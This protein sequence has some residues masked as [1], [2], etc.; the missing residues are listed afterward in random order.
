MNGC[1]T[2]WSGD[3]RYGVRS[4]AMAPGFVALAVLCLGPGIGAA[5]LMFTAVDS[6]LLEPPPFAEPDRLVAVTQV[7]ET[8]P[9]SRQPVSLGNYRELREGAADAAEAAAMRAATFRLGSGEAARRRAGALATANLFPVLGIEPALGRG[10]RAEDETAAP[11]PVVLLS[12]ETWRRDFAGDG[13][14][15]G[16]TVTVDGQARTI[17]GVLPRLADARMPREIREARIWVPLERSVS[18]TDTAVTVIARLAAG[19]TLEHAAARFGSIGTELATRYPESMGS[20][21]RVDELGGSVSRST[22]DMLLLGMGSAVLVLLI[23]CANVANLLL[24]R[25]TRRRP[26]LAIRAALGASPGRIVRQLLFESLA[27]GVLGAVLGLVVARWSRDALLRALA[28]LQGAEITMPIDASVLAFTIGATVLS[29]LLFGLVPALQVG[30]GSAPPMLRVSSFSASTGRGFTRFRHTLVVGQVGWA[31][32]LLAGA[33][34]LLRSFVSLMAV[35]G[36]IDTENLL[37]VELSRSDGEEARAAPAMP[38]VEGMLAALAAL[39]GVESAAAADFLP[40]RTSGRRSRVTLRDTSIETDRLPTISYASVTERFFETLRTRLLQGSGFTADVTER[41]AP[42]A[43]VNERMAGQLWRRADPLGKRFDLE[44][45][46]GLPSITVI[47]VS[48]DIANWDQS[49]VPLATAYVRFDDL[50]V[51]PSQLLLRMN[52]AVPASFE[53]LAGAIRSIAPDVEV[54]EVAAMEDVRRGAFWRQELFS[55]TLAVFGAAA[56]LLSVL[57]LYGVLTYLVRLRE[58][59]I[60]IRIALGAGPGRVVRI[61]IGQ[62][63]R[64]VAAGVALGLVGALVL[65]RLMRG[66]LFG[67]GP[68]DAPLF[69][70]VTAVLVAVAITASVAPACRAMRVDPSALLRD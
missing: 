20:T 32:A 1:L 59:E 9:G 51:F 66:L 54:L 40:L 45:M 27:L 47:G 38:D 23:A 37:A 49:G 35:E 4:L 56:L 64:L 13:D 42:V 30:R 48:R 16:A 34:L 55:S 31:L 17:I 50:E 3:L 39:P 6:L 67:V 53:A 43:V 70:G 2:G 68:F 25:A 69:A 29:S 28:E 22:R 62:G 12:D 24:A 63:A 26:E 18:P 21:L 44:A 33:A 52:G 57:G 10:F 65:G 41:G 5:A 14:V 7:R 19:V 11:S 36:G 61:V 8:A 46:P 60:G 58:R 15:I